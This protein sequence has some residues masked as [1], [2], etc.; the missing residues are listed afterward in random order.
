MKFYIENV[1]LSAV[2]RL[3]ID[4]APKLQKSKKNTQF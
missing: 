1:F 2:Q 3:R 4:K